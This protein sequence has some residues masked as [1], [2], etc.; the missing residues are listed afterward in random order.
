[1]DIYEKLY[2]SDDQLLSTIENG[3]VFFDTSALL[4]L[5]SLSQPACD[6]VFNR[7]L[8]YY[9]NRL[10]I[11][12]RVF[13]EFQKNRHGVSKKP[14]S[15]YDNLL[16]CS[17]SRD[18]GYVQKIVTFIETDFQSTLQSLKG[19]YQ[20]L[21]E[22]CV[23]NKKHPIIDKSEFREFSGKISAFEVAVNA[24]FSDAQRF[25]ANIASVVQREKQKIEDQ[26]DND[27]IPE[28]IKSYF[29]IGDPYSYDELLDIAYDGETRYRLKIPPGYEDQED[30]EG[31]AVFGDLI[32]WKQI[33]DYASSNK[34][35]AIL[36][37]ED[38][39]EDWID[40]A[41]KK[42][43]IELL[44]EYYSVTEC[45]FEV[46]NLSEFLHLTNSKLTTEKVTEST[47]LEVDSTMMHD[48]IDN[49]QAEETSKHSNQLAYSGY[50]I[51]SEEAFLQV[52][53]KTLTSH[54]KFGGFLSSKYFVETVLAN[55]GFDIRSCW[56]MFNILKE[57]GII[58]EK[59]HDPENGY[60]PLSVVY[61]SGN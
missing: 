2:L 53:K 27:I 43:R 54:K 47:L 11:P 58:L 25:Q 50:Y 18:G 51:I 49:E 28:K 32:I 39:K 30:K 34:K 36:V 56:N 4:N 55:Q 5:Y 26:L 42:P 10:W 14:L 24:L 3:N 20:A 6:E 7:V 22:R 37:S 48:D 21:V 60:P 44:L 8:D 45:Q 61:I 13:F 33:L 40:V 59:Q 15:H 31:L 57:R 38:K 35:S 19:Q 9:R 16:S 29:S 12:N 1:M 17:N 23:D 46:L 52:L 41:T